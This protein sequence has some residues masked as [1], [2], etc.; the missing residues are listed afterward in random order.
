VDELLVSII[1]LGVAVTAQ[2]A[3]FA[4]WLGRKFGRIEDRLR[5]FDKRFED[6]GN[7]L[8]KLEKGFYDFRS[9]VD[10]KFAEID[11]R[12]E[13][14]DRR[15][16]E[17]RRAISSVL[18]ASMSMSTL[19]VDFLALKGLVTED[20][21]KFLRGQIELLAS[22]VSI[23]P[24]TKEEAEFLKKVF[25]K[26]EDQITIEELDKVLE[27][28]KRWFFETGEEK[29]YKLWLYTYMYRAAL[30]YERL[31]KEREKKQTQKEPQAQSR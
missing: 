4:Y 1:G 3:A 27:I 31:R 20:E 14:L 18:T 25:S 26:S 2:I 21:R 29:A 12:L 9:Y 11:R 8:D 19:I 28:A 13:D 17:T 6:F 10:K 7:R 30:L 16:A 23:N 24:L 5:E 22:E 15:I